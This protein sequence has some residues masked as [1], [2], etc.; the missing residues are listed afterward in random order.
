MKGKHEQ[1]SYTKSARKKQKKKILIGDAIYWG[2]L[3]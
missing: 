1:G 2:M 3:R